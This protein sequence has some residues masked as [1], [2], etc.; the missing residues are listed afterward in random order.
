MN[1]SLF[2]FKKLSSI[3]F[4][5]LLIFLVLPTTGQAAPLVYTE[6]PDLTENL[7]IP[8]NLGSVDVGVNTITGAI[9]AVNEGGPITGGDTADSFEYVVPA[10]MVATS[11]ELII[12]NFSATDGASARARTFSGGTSLESFSGDVTYPNLINTGSGFLSAGTYDFQVHSIHP[13]D[14]EFNEIGDVSFN[15]VVN[16]NVVP[17][18]DVDIELSATKSIDPVVAGS[19]IDNLV[20]ELIAVNNG[21]ADATG[22]VVD[23]TYVLPPGVIPTSIVPSQGSVDNAGVWTVG[24]LTVAQG[25][26]MVT[27]TLTVDPTT[28]PGTDVISGEATV[29]AVTENDWNSIN[30]T[31]IGAV[32]VRETSATFRVGKVFTDGNAA[33][34]NMT[35]T[36]NDVI[37]DTGSVTD[38]NFVSLTATGFLQDGFGTTNCVVSEEVLAGYFPAYSADCDVTAVDSAANATDG[39]GVYACTVTN[40]NTQTSFNVIKTFSDGNTADVEVTLTCNSGLPLVQSFT[41]AGGDPVGVNFVVTGYTE[42]T[43][44]CDVTETGSP[45]GYAVTY[46]NCSWDN[47]LSADTH[48]CVISNT[49]DAATFTVNKEWELSAGGDAVLEQVVVIAF[50]DNPISGGTFDAP[51]QRWYISDVLG[52]GDSLTAIVDTTLSSANCW[53]EEPDLESGV[54]S[55]DDCG[56]RTIP[57]GGSSSCTFTNTVFFEGIPTLS[58][59]GLAILALLMLGVGM[60]GFRRFA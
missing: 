45:A 49:A 28:A 40:D 9:A 14:G 47:V 35:L 41:I 32:S 33:S 21:P 29:S 4:T 58:Q 37:E 16:I 55:E 12:T 44:N 30:D 2:R 6:P 31:V 22:L 48:N 39:D 38:G 18:T 11:F 19:G 5:G 57:A 10:G 54:E 20:L 26:V 25:A 15:W 8:D 7:A 51:N 36:C 42:G 53:A 43:M 1:A 13:L 24:D 56:P 3:I 17:D 27:A 52:D 23:T 59:Y 46:D 60:V 50:C 34:V